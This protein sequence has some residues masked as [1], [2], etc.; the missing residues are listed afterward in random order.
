MSR[1]KIAIL[2]DLDPFSTPGAN[3]VALEYARCANDEY[4]IEFWTGKFMNSARSMKASGAKLNIKNFYFSEQFYAFP[5]QS[6]R[7]KTL[8]E[9][10]SLLPLLWIISRA[11]VFKPSLVWVHQI[12]NVFPISSLLVFRMLRIPVVFTLHDFGI[13]LPRKLYPG[14]LSVSSKDL[15]DLAKSRDIAPEKLKLR[16]SR[17]FQAYSL[18][19]YVTRFLVESATLVSISDMQRKILEANKF[20]VSETIENGVLPCSCNNNST[21]RLDAVL[22]AGRLNGKGLLHAIDTV[23]MN[24][25]LVLHLAGPQELI[26]TALQKLPKRR[27]VYHGELSQPELFRLLHRVKFTSVMSD[28]FDVYPSILLEAVVHGSAPLCYPTVGNAALANNVS[29]S[30]LVE[31]G[32]VTDSFVLYRLCKDQNLSQILSSSGKK[33]K[34]FDEVYLRYS[35]LFSRMLRKR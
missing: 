33:L 9:L 34:S 29:N 21:S 25:E 17:F 4:D 3:L 5:R 6:L 7:K 30:L 23:T 14:D 2:T 13:L 27:V 12:G 18:R 15:M 19:L 35:K 11:L 1:G 28:C 8:R 22:F 10:F 20:Y 31:F 16:N 32:E 26:A 24:S